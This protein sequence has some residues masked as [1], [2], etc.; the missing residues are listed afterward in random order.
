MLNSNLPHDILHF[1]CLSLKI[2]N[3]PTLFP[4]DSSPF[5]HRQGVIPVKDYVNAGKPVSILINSIE[6]NV[7]QVPK[8]VTQVTVVFQDLQQEL[9]HLSIM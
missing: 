2:T 7:R 1:W 4:F 5:L 3:W 9:D 6:A 8:G